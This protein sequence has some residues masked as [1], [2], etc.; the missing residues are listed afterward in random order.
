[1]KF[2]PPLNMAK[3][4]KELL[5]EI[6]KVRS[7]SAQAWRGSWNRPL[8]IDQKSQHPFTIARMTNHSVR[9][10]DKPI[11]GP[12]SLRIL[13]PLADRANQLPSDVLVLNDD[14]ILEIPAK[15]ST[16]E[17]KRSQL[18]AMEKLSIHN[19]NHSEEEYFYRLERE[20]RQR[21]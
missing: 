7:L 2:A 6:P 19:S 18:H 13:P 4:S 17:P 9:G 12:P 5:R 3:L 11:G 14:D 1:M 15:N 20:S 16:A 10:P 8:K 21:D